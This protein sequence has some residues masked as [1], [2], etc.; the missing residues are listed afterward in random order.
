MVRGLTGGEGGRD[1]SVAGG[2]DTSLG[3]TI[4]SNST[5]VEVSTDETVVGKGGGEIRLL[6]SP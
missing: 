1:V 3:H 6:Y 2:E 5:D 4:P